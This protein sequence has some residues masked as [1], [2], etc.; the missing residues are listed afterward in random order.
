MRLIVDMTEADYAQ[1]K[2]FAWTNKTSMR[3][4]V[5]RG[6]S[7]CMGEINQDNPERTEAEIEYYDN[8]IKRIE[9]SGLTIGEAAYKMGM[10]ISRLNSIINRY[11]PVLCTHMKKAGLL[12]SW[13]N[14]AAIYP[15]FRTP[16]K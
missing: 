7:L 11:R 3:K 5:M 9:L 4:I 12:V 15:I 16:P 2:A 10:G 6:L 13:I 14:Q 1:L 8:F